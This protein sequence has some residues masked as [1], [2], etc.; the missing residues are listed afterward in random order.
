MGNKFPYLFQAHPQFIESLY[1]DFQRDPESIDPSWRKF[2]EGYDFARQHLKAAPEIPEDVEKEFRVLNL[3]HGYRTRGHFFTKTNPVRARRK[4]RPT[5]DIENFGLSEADLDKVFQAGREIGLGPARLRD[6]VEYLQQTYCHSIG[7]EYMYIRYPERVKWL[8]ER[9]EST[10]NRPN[11]TTEDKRHILHKLNQA[12]VFEKFL[13]TKYVGQKRFALS[14]GETLI[15]GLDAIIEKGAELGAREFVIGMAHRGRLNVLANILNKSYEEIFAEF[16]G[17][18]LETD[19]FEGD[20]KYHLGYS[21]DVKTRSG[22]TVHLSL[23]PNPSHLEAVDPVVEGTARAKIDHL[24]GGDLK[25]LIPILIHGDAAIAGQGVVYEVVQMAQLPGYRTGGTIHIVINNQVG[26]TTNYLEGRSSIYCTDVGKV[27]HSPIFHVNADDVE[28]VVWAVQLAVAYRQEFHTD[29][30]ID[31][32]GYRRYG[33]NEADEPRFTQP[34]LY[35]IIERHPDPRQIYYQK[36]LEGGEVERG[37]AEEMEKE[38]QKMLQERLEKVKKEPVK[39]RITPFRAYW[40]GF[41]EPRSED[42]ENPPETAVEKSHLKHLAEKIFTIPPD[43]KVFRKIRR[44]FDDRRKRVLE[45]EEVDWA[46]AEWLAYATLLDEGVPIRLSG[47]DSRRGTFAHR[48]AVLLNED[49]EE[50]YI[51]LNHIK[52]GQPAFEIYNSPL[53]EYGVMGFEFGYAWATPRGLTIWEAQFGDFANGA[54]IIIDQFLCCS[55]QKWKK[56]NGLV[57]YLPHGYEGQGPEHS[58]ARIERFLTLSAGLNWQVVYPTTPA[59]MFHVLRRQMKFPFRIPLILFT[60]K[61]LLRHPLCVSTLDELAEKKFQEV[62]DDPVVHPEAVKVVFFC[63]GKIY[64]DLI[65]ERQKRERRDIAFVRLEQLYPLPIRQ[66]QQIIDRYAHA[67]KFVWVQEEPENM[68]AWPFLRRKFNL[69]RLDV[70]ARRESAS[71]ATGFHRVHTMEQTE[72]LD[73]VFQVLSTSRKREKSIT[74]FG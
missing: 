28:A 8:Q 58:S 66:L 56:V 42:F 13:H 71:P 2:F 46:I 51:P 20:V 6:I 26:F 47:Q 69:V 70:I 30:F 25:K 61:S 4:Y 37:I 12:V 22:K 1:Q 38:F 23:S 3:I 44:L 34:K 9:M 65:Q 33:H 57:V 48:H 32:L 11:L 41:R 35:K 5:L 18:M 60:P 53:S 7:V 54:Q 74:I 10:R 16:E 19:L 72:I 24:Y 63:S 40:E 68:G 50:E 67:K 45:K 21:N 73:K 39:P 52:E 59:N 43:I 29:V 64:Y 17:E 55:Y 15:P 14:G 49:T 62:I 27:T 36:L 31:L